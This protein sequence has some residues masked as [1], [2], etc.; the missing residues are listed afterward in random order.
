MRTLKLSLREVDED[1]FYSSV[2][3]TLPISGNCEII[4]K[5]LE[6]SYLKLLKDLESKGWPEKNQF[7]KIQK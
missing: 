3:I 6:M 2:Q 5:L 4:G 7:H 1:G